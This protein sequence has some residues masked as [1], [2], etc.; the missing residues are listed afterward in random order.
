M[1]ARWG[2]VP[3]M[4]LTQTLRGLV[5]PDVAKELCMSAR[6]IDGTMAQT[7]GLVTHVD[8]DPV[9]RARSLAVEFTTRSPDAVLA[10][11]RVIDAMQ[12]PVSRALRLEKRW[13]LKLLRG[14]NMRI[15][16]QRAQRPE[17]P[18]EPRQYR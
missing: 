6:I 10:A 11:K 1:E 9:A 17:R 14:R 15:A 2:L 8:A 7:L 13:Q 3:D 18:F 12:G 4:G 5:R 16:R